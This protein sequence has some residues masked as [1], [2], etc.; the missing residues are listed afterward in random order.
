[1][2]LRDP[3][4]G[5]RESVCGLVQKTQMGAGKSFGEIVFACMY[6]ATCGFWSLVHK[7]NIFPKARTSAVRADEVV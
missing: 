6:L 1:M 4:L 3:F 7:M 2:S 5:Q